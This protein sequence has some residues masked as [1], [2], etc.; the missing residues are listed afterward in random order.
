MNDILILMIIPV[1]W[2]GLVALARLAALKGRP[3]LADGAE[4]LIM[5]LMLLP[6]AGGA[7]LLTLAPLTGSL[8]PAPILLAAPDQDAFVGSAPLSHAVT[9]SPGVPPILPL[10]ALILYAI[11]ALG[12]MA[13]LSL[14]YVRL[15]RIAAIAKPQDGVYVSEANVPAFAW[16]R[17]RI[18]L[19]ARLSS[20][21]PAA[22]KAL[23]VAHERAHLTRR[24]PLWFLILSVTEALLWFNPVIRL[25]G[26]ACRLAAELACDTAVVGDRPALRL[27]YARALLAALKDS[28]GTAPSFLPAA[29]SCDAKAYRH[30]LNH[31]M[32]GTPRP[33]RAMAW[34]AAVLVL[35]IPVTA[36]Q[37]AFARE[38]PANAPVSPAAP[39]TPTIV[40]P[41]DAPISSHFGIRKK[42]LKGEMAFHEGVDFAAPLGTP[43]KAHAAGVVSFAGTRYGYGTTIEIDNGGKITTRY[44]HL[45]QIDVKAGDTVT[46]GQMIA[47]I[48]QPSVGK[49]PHLHFELWRDHKPVDPAPLFATQP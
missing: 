16:G 5:V 9:L 4:K 30:R 27:A 41:V 35:A 43:V 18:V 48:G 17:R 44:A 10:V 25:Q 38:A 34:I 7:L 49:T 12:L 31:I 42:P 37:L 45:G 32:T 13:R 21:L 29:A 14:A 19:P 24:D 36:A 26:R 46:A 28:A 47:D 6:I 33:P 3:A 22:D 39:A 40:R 8:M 11:I 1:A 23:I 2:S 20:L 15:A